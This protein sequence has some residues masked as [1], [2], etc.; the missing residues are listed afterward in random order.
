MFKKTFLIL[1]LIIFS[2]LILS[3][4]VLA[5]EEELEITYPTVPGAQ[6]PT[7]VKT[8]LPQYVKYIFNFS[9]WIAGL[10][11]FVAVLY[12]GV[13]YLTSA[14]DP[15]ATADARD[16]IFAGILGLIII[17][18][19]YTILVNINPQL[20]VLRVNIE[21]TPAAGEI[22]GVYLCKSAELNAENCVVY[23]MTSDTIDPNFDDNFTNV[24]LKNT[25]TKVYGVVLHEDKGRR[26]NCEV[27][28]SNGSVGIKASSITV[29]RQGGGGGGGVTL[30]DDKEFQDGKWGHIGP[31]TNEVQIN[32][33]NTEKKDFDNETSSVKIDG[34][35][36]VVLS[37]EIKLAGDCLALFQS[38]EY[39]RS[40]GFNNN[41]KS[42]RILFGK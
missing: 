29:F 40:E 17:L 37:K 1:I 41:V 4:F 15:T 39:L 33:I 38:D 16:Q 36:I 25:T 10:V 5:Q 28:T 20:V 2:A 14:G 35:Y 19:A 22:P 6:T 3:D 7:Q 32:D 31:Y 26:G 34:K 23:T 42:F 9:I 11:A 18:S 8:P 12:G 24:F 21:G 30:Y 13:R 27:H